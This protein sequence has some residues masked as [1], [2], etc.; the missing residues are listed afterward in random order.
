MKSFVQFLKNLLRICKECRENPEK[1]FQNLRIN[2]I[3]TVANVHL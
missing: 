1:S 3:D 2:L